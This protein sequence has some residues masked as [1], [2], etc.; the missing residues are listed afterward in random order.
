M[1]FLDKW[2][3]KESQDHRVNKVHLD[4]NAEEPLIS[5]GAKVHVLR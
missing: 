5:G 3:L 1:V 2:D 4:L